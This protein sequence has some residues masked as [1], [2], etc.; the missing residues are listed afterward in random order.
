MNET[1]LSPSP[2][3]VPWPTSE[4]RARVPDT[5]MLP[6]S[7]Q[8]PPAA[9]GMLKDAVQGAH[10]TIDRLADSAAPA[11]QRMGESAAAAEDALHAKADELSALRDEWV[12]RVR[13]TVRANP[14]LAVAGAVALGLVLARITSVGRADR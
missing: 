9:V 8:A 14:L 13:T 12:D 11:V 1:K 3:D 7:E 2:A 5:S 4:E 6:D 10:A